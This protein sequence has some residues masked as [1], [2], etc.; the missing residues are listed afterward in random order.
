M[1]PHTDLARFVF[2]LQFKGRGG[3]PRVSPVKQKMQKNK[4]VVQIERQVQDY[5]FVRLVLVADG[6]AASTV[7]CIRTDDKSI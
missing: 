6:V 7:S 3:S 2:K 5:Y 1:C 4:V